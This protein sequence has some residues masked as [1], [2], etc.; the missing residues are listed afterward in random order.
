M[1]PDPRKETDVNDKP[2][3]PPDEAVDALD[4]L[5]A[6]DVEIENLTSMLAVAKA[7]LD[8]LRTQFK[9]AQK[10]RNQLSRS[11]RSNAM[12]LFDRP[13]DPERARAVRED[14]DI[15]RPTTTYDDDVADGV[16]AAE[17]RR[18]GEWDLDGSPISPEA[19]PKLTGPAR[20]KKGRKA[21]A[22]A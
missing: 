10:A 7:A 4:Q 9:D 5:L 11:I 20:P 22:Q 19:M 8:D 2:S 12:P 21:A 13:I 3:L 14:L 15:G 6:R 1:F 17:A 18:E 16:R